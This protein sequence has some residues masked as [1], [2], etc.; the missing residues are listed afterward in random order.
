MVVICMKVDTVSKQ[1]ETDGNVTVLLDGVAPMDVTN[2]IIQ[3][4]VL[5]AALTFLLQNQPLLNQPLQALLQ[6]LQHTLLSAPTCLMVV[7]CT[8]EAN[9]S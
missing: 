1:A 9:V 8:R 5:E 2:H 6:L 4:S 7:I 3:A